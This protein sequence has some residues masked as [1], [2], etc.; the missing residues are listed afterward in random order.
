MRVTVSHR[1]TPI[2]RTIESSWSAVEHRKDGITELVRRLRMRW[3]N[4]I[5][6]LPL[7]NPKLRLWRRLLFLFRFIAG[8]KSAICVTE[9]IA[10]GIGI[11]EGDIT[12]STIQFYA[13]H[14]LTHP[15]RPSQPTLVQFISHIL[16]PYSNINKNI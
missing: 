9:S 5:T 14:S 2:W 13:T 1:L 16:L 8:F 4:W 3:C 11:E 12:H 7:P 6:T 15:S 10:V